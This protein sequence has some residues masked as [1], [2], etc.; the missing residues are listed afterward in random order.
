MEDER[1]ISVIAKDLV[2]VKL[3]KATI[4]EIKN[5]FFELARK[6]NIKQGTRSKDGVGIICDSFEWTMC[7]ELF[8]RRIIDEIELSF[9][10][11]EVPKDL[12]AY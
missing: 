4:E 1:E 2:A 5:M 6:H 8:L 9:L 10:L 11:E 7:K 12:E 3:P